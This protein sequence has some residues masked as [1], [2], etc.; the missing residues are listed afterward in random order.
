MRVVVFDVFHLSLFC[1][2]YDV[3]PLVVCADAYFAAF[4]E[5]SVFFAVVDGF[6]ERRVL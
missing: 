4:G 1:E 3:C 6:F 2:L 5:V